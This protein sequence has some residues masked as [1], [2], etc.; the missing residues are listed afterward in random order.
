MSDDHWRPKRN[1]YAAILE[2]AG[3]L[4]MRRQPTRAKRLFS[5]R[6]EREI[7]EAD[8]AIERRFRQKDRKRG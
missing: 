2:A 7:A 5:D 8:E 4:R 6:E 3:E 1:R